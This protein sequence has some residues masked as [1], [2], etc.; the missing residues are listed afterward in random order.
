MLNRWKCL[1]RCELSV[2]LLVILGFLKKSF[3]LKEIYFN[4]RFICTFSEETANGNSLLLRLQK[5]QKGFV[6]SN[7]ILSH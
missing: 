7:L 3:F 2:R 5:L 1:R 6:T 4:L